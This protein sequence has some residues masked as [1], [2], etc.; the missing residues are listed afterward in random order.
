MLI[1]DID[2]LQTLY[3]E[4]KSIEDSSSLS[5]YTSGLVRGALSSIELQLNGHKS[6]GYFTGANPRIV[7]DDSLIDLLNDIKSR[8]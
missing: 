2:E 3:D 8:V 5:I 6:I 4:I 7:L 1:I